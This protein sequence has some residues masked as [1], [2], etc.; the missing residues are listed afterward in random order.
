[1]DIRA[2]MLERARLLADFPG[3]LLPRVTPQLMER[4]R[5]IAAGT[6]RFYG[7]DP[8]AIG[9]RGIDWTGAHIAHQEWPAQLNR[10]SYLAPLAAAYRETG[11]SLYAEAARSYIEDW[12]TGGERYAGRTECRP[13]DNTLN[14]SIRLGSSHQSGWGGVLPAFLSSA[15]FGDA[16][17]GAVLESMAEQATFLSGHL[18]PWG[19]W[20]I[21]QLDSLVFTAL[22][23]PFLPGAEGLLRTGIQGM[24]H[25][26][27]TQF[28]PDG[29]HIERTPSYAA[30]MTGV[31]VS[32]H[33]L[34][35]VVPEADAHVP[36][37]MVLR[38]LDYLAHSDL[39]GLHDSTAPHQDSRRPDGLAR[40]RALLKLAFP[41][42]TPRRSPPREQVFAHAGQVFLRSAW[43]SKADY[44]SFDAT[45]WG[46]GHGHLS[47]LSFAF[48]SRGRM[49][50]ADPGIL[51]YEM[52]DPMG[53]YGK[54]T[55]AHSTLNVN[56]LNQSEANPHL[57]RTELT[58]ATALIQAAYAGGYW[59]GDYGW[60]FRR[61]HGRGAFGRHER[62][63]FWVKGEYLIALD[64]L[65]TEPGQEVQNVWQLGPMDEWSADQASRTWWSRNQDA[66]LF[67]QLVSGPDDAAMHCFE[68]SRDPIR[69]WVGHHGHDAVP[70]P[71]VELR[72]RS[73]SYGAAASAVLLVPFAGT[74][75]PA[76][77]VEETGHA[78]GRRVHWLRLRLPDGSSDHIIWSKDLD[79]PAEAMPAVATDATFVWLRT[80][81]QGRPTNAF[82]LDG[83][84]LMYAGRS[85]LES[86]ER[87]ARLLNLG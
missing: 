79:C 83:S 11:E 59:E 60:S 47:R 66:N 4:A 6:I 36:R 49:L 27:A 76:Y 35:G 63:L 32:Y 9:L 24:R 78:L 2:T 16:F 19:N 18:T 34:P 5:E 29:V 51:S 23:L 43:R 55:R 61:G 12:M 44:L 22:R 48:R 3:Q 39:S 25:A 14:I 41:D 84:Y 82:L 85:L 81:S 37:E 71:L 62:V 21:A 67:L 26:L 86:G 28:L 70:A 77:R 65:E 57:L 72:Y 30:W 1:M 68:G 10:F 54:S 87:M 15:A 17:L 74:E 52:S 33:R 73:P 75:K 53:P 50:V 40:R 20:R 7:T 38:A 31:L 69:G 42:K 58:P 64:H 80:T 13:G 45:T 8:V 46:G 56:G